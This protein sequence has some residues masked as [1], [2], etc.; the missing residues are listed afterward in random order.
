M[1][2]NEVA[3]RALDGKRYL[4]SGP[5]DLTTPATSVV[6]LAVSGRRCEI[7]AGGPRL[8]DDVLAALGATGYDE[9]LVYAGGRLAIARTEPYDPQIR[10]RE[11]RLTGVW[12]GK[13]FSFFT[14]LYGAT[15][16]DLL[17]VLSGFA[18]R[19]HDDGIAITP[20]RPHGFAG[21]ATL[22]KEVPGLGL[23]EISP[24]TPQHTAQL[25]RWRGMTTQAGELFV[26]E[27]SDG[28][29]YFVLAGSDTWTTVL[30]LRDTELAEVPRLVGE[31]R[32]RTAV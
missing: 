3:H 24:L 9:E 26:D 17:S 11:N 10:L 29:P 1:S 23:L 16:N 20:H 13:R 32:L 31:L 5:F 2:D 15:S 8:G 22:V 6:E 12:L 7:T 4:L 28:S 18:I 30:P 21:T 25:P 14:H 19:E 27:L